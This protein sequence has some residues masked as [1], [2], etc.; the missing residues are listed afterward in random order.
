MKKKV[1]VVGLGLLLGMS[2]GMQAFAAPQT[3]SD[4]TVFDAAYYAQAN[5]D[6]V[7]VYGT[8][9]KALYRHY[10]EYGRS[11]GR[12]ATDPAAGTG[13][14]ATGTTGTYED[15]FDPAFYAARYP[16]VAAVFTTPEG[17]YYHYTVA[18][19]AE[20]RYPNVDAIPEKTYD[21]IHTPNAPSTAQGRVADRINV[22]RWKESDKFKALSWDDDLAAAAQ[23]RAE[24]LVTRFDHTRLNGAEWDSVLPSKFNSSHAEIINREYEDPDL[25][26]NAWEAHYAEY[27]GEGK[28]REWVEGY[29][30]DGYERRTIFDK[31][32]RWIGVGH[33][34]NDAGQP[35]WAILFA[36]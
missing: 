6:V 20:G 36:E 3:M 13:A 14:S 25:L 1:S 32:Y 2:F 9:T 18:G 27:R 4:G 28:D 30:N 26:V 22:F 15:G 23:L 34:H 11:E 12:A 33:A 19:K 29:I 21:N 7:A 24:E 31:Y 5:P 16:D 17:L 10:T 35:F 8:K